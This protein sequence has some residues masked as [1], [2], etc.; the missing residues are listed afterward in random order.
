VNWVR[1]TLGRGNA[2]LRAASLSKGLRM[3]VVASGLWAG[4]GSAGLP[5]GVESNELHDTG[6]VTGEGQKTSSVLSRALS[7]IEERFRQ[8]QSDCLTEVGVNRKSLLSVETEET[9]LGSLEDQ[10]SSYLY[11]SGYTEP[12]TTTATQNTPAVRMSHYE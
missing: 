8:R 2:A 9:Q 12:S 4:V 10:V 6:C 5:G 7:R 11:Y 1:S 3:V